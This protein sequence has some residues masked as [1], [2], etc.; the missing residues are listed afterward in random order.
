MTGKTLWDV[1]KNPSREKIDAWHRIEHDITIRKGYDVVVRG[2][3]FSFSVTYKYEDVEHYLH[4]VYETAC[5]SSD[6]I[7][8]RVSDVKAVYALSAFNGYGILNIIGGE[9]CT[10]CYLYDGKI[11]DIKT[12]KIHC[13]LS[14]RTYIIRN[15]RKLYLDNFLRI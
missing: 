3:S 10:S 2:S 8:Y 1:Y 12:T 7:M 9:L 5:N 11:S 14:G 4:L 6:T 13:S 15:K